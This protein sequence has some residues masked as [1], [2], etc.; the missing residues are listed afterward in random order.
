MKPEPP[1]VRVECYGENVLTV[2]PG[3]EIPTVNFPRIKLL[4]WRLDRIAQR[5][6]EPFQDGYVQQA[7]ANVRWLVRKNLVEEKVPDLLSSP[8][9]AR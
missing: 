8:F 6:A 2:Q 4:V 1:I 3:D 9:P 7:P 5:G